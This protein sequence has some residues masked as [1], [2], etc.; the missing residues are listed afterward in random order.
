MITVF[1]FIFWTVCSGNQMK[2]ESY[3]HLALAT[4]PYDVHMLIIHEAS[5][6]QSMA[7]V[8]RKKL[9]LT[10]FQYC[11]WQFPLKFKFPHD[12][13]IMEIDGYCHIF[14]IPL[15]IWLFSAEIKLKGLL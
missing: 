1:L 14:P 6:F 2:H 7:L 9:V 10:L 5:K 13:P 4:K 3:L 12:L 15:F 11:S 8:L